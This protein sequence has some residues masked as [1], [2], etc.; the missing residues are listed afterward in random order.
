M[1]GDRKAGI[2]SRF[3]G[4]L[5]Q[6][7]APP[8]AVEPVEAPDETLPIGSAD[9]VEESAPV[10]V[11]R[12]RTGQGGDRPTVQQARAAK[13]VKGH[14]VYLPDDLF[15]RILVQSH[16]KGQTISEYISALLNRHVPDHLR[17]RVSGDDA[18]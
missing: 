12:K 1:A 9:P 5:E 4:V 17:G 11:P 16:R 14:T 18:A 3:G 7:T 10:P 2:G 15:E 6:A 8:R 13:R